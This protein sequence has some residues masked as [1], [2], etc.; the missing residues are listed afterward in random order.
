MN[1]HYEAS[2]C[3][4]S[5]AFHCAGIWLP[6]APGT[7]M[8]VLARVLLPVSASKPLHPRGEPS[9]WEITKLLLAPPEPPRWVR[10]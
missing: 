7:A 1:W 8:L 6:D 10:C 2:C 3:S 5:P 9:A 4:L